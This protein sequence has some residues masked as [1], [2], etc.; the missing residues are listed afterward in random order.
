MN[1]AIALFLF[2]PPSWLLSKTMK[3][4]AIFVQAAPVNKFACFVFEVNS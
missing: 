4:E 3:S 2:K 1:G